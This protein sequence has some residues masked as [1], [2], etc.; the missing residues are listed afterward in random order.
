ME[1][2]RAYESN[3]RTIRAFKTMAESALQIGR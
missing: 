1:A 2:M 3:L